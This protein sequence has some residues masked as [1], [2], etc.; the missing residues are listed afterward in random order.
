MQGEQQGNKQRQKRRK[1]QG[2]K[3]SQ[4]QSTM[5]GCGFNGLARGETPREAL[6]HLTH[7][8]L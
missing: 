8:N 7:L 5:Q 4:R 1:K 3:Q 2:K 6:T